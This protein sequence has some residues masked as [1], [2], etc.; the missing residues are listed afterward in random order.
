MKNTY[1]NKL[2]MFSILP[3]YT[4]VYISHS[5]YIDYDIIGKS[6]WLTKLSDSS[7]RRII[8]TD[9]LT[10]LNQYVTIDSL[11]S[12]T[13]YKIQAAYYDAMID[14]QLL[15]AKTGYLLSNEQTFRTRIA[16]SITA[17]NISATPVEVGVSLPL[18]SLTISGEWDTLQIQYKLASDT[19]WSDLYEGGASTSPSISMM[20][21]TYNFRCRGVYIL[22]DGLTSDAS[23]WYQWPSAITIDYQQIPPSAPTNLQ[24]V[25][26]KINDSFEHYDLKL[27]CV[28]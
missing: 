23:S 18:V 3:T 7:V 24:Y 22:P 28:S 21:G 13:N 10:L 17:I 12:N 5:P 25:V 26:A 2:E 19:V 4:K 20:P 11:T 8:N 15:E 27:T 14:S 9:S 6:I 1:P 16:P